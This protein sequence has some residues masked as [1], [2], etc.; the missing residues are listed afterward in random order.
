[1]AKLL[2]SAPYFPVADVARSVKLYESYGFH[3][4]YMPGEPPQFAIVSKDGLAVM[5]RRVA[6]PERITPVEAQGGTWDAFF[7]V[8]DADALHRE[9]ASHG[10]QVIY[11]PLVQ[12][13]GVKE[14]AVRDSDGHVLGFGQQ[15]PR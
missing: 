7:W 8:D 3:C 10:A 4:D 6:A 9:M 1:M 2:R 15:W 14:F 11:G 5:F 13:Y 12:D